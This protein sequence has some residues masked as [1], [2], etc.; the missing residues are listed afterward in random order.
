MTAAGSFKKAITFLLAV[1][2]LL[3]I[4]FVAAERSA[5]AE[6][7]NVRVLLSMKEVPEVEMTVKGSYTLLETGTSFSGGKLKLTASGNTVT[8]VHSVQGELFTGKTVSVSRNEKTASAGSMTFRVNGNKRSYLGDFSVSASNG[9]I[10]IV[11][12][13]PLVYYL[14][15]VVGHEMSNTWPVE[16]LKAQAMAAKN[17]VLARLSTSGKYD[18]N[19]TASDQ[20]YK[21][22]SGNLKNVIA[23]V[24][25]TIQNAL[26]LNGKIVPCYYAASNGGFTKL[27]SENWGETPFDEV[28]V[29]GTDPFDVENTLSR[30]ESI[31]IPQNLARRSFSS[32]EFY[33]FF[34]NKLNEA[35]AVPGAIPEGYAFD[36]FSEISSILSLNKNGIASNDGDHF[37][38]VITADVKLK[39]NSA[40]QPPV[41]TPSPEP[42][43]VPKTEPAS[44]GEDGIL[45]SDETES[46]ME[47]DSL[48]EE[49]IKGSS[50]RKTSIIVKMTFKEIEDEGFFKD[51]SLRIYYVMPAD[52]GWMLF[53]GRFG[54]GVGMSQRG[55]QQMAKEGW[56]Y[57]Q[58]LSF[59]YP[60]ATMQTLEYDIP[61]TPILVKEEDSPEN[62]NE[63][64]IVSSDSMLPGSD[65]Q[66]QEEEAEEAEEIK[67]DGNGTATR[68]TS[69]YSGAGMNS[70]IV[71]QINKGD[72]FLVSNISGNWYLVRDIKT[73]KVGYIYSSDL[74]VSGDKS[75]ATAVI[76]A[77]SVNFR[78]GPGTDFESLGRLDKGDKV[79]ILSL[80]KEWNGI[81]TQDGQTGYVFNKYLRITGSAPKTETTFNE[82][83]ANETE[84]TGEPVFLAPVQEDPEPVAL[85]GKYL[86][87]GEA[88]GEEAGS[89]ITFR[90]GQSAA[91]ESLGQIEE[92]TRFGILEKDGA[93]F[94]VVLLETG[95][96][97]YLEI[98]NLRLTENGSATDST[99]IA[100]GKINESGIQLRTGP[101]LKYDSIETVRENTLVS[102]LGSNHEWF[103]VLVS[104]T[105]NTGYIPAQYVDLDIMGKKQGSTGASG[106]ATVNTG[107]MNIYSSPDLKKGKVVQILRRGYTVTV[108]SI[109]DE[110]ANVSFNGESGYCQ[111]KYLKMK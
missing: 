79:Y 67:V 80:G 97:G 28:Y 38:I 35:A 83:T 49:L 41:P 109:T 31:Y 54:H 29:K 66:G 58:I 92:G 95:Q 19:D 15:G 27:P 75:L 86:A 26:Y 13:V 22:Y 23:A 33:T 69:M 52:E 96:K 73:N 65:P 84:N 42:T 111:L 85:P 8:A 71:E 2:L 99:V 74:E 48:Q 43:S 106:M 7:I 105:G 68:S 4:V 90:V 94:R 91:A 50:D 59:Y 57:E 47:D 45:V 78:T 108:H 100:A 61:A 20:V 62:G 46:E 81:K 30:T 40:V 77:A 39:P 21:G 11:N 16:A 70:K 6:D 103:L 107:M 72:K 32:K 93:W 89:E 12:T 110:W 14:Y 101:S 1:V 5:K 9:Q 98:K 17:Y 34:M 63:T 51:S 104:N 102:V 10:V 37:Q 82:Q 53:H 64:V 87:F 36:S 3:S 60:G 76:S 55:A 24:D 88:V 44:D 56:T 25:G 18:V